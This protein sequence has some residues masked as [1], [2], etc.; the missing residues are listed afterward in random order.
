MV[1]PRCTAR[2]FGERLNPNVVMPVLRWMLRPRVWRGLSLL[3]PL[4][5]IARRSSASPRNPWDIRLPPI[6]RELLST[7]GERVDANQEL[8]AF[9]RHPLQSFV[10]LHYESCVWEIARGWPV[11]LKFV[12]MLARADRG[13][14]RADRNSRI[15]SSVPKTGTRAADASLTA[16]LRSYASTLGIGALGVTA[17]DRKYMTEQGIGTE[18]GDRVVIVALEQQYAATQRTPSDRSLAATYDSEAESLHLTVRLVQFLQAR[19]FRAHAH[20]KCDGMTIP[21]A[22]AA[23]MGQLGLNGQLLTPAVGSRCRLYML[24]T[25]APLV[26]DSPVDYGIHGICDRCQACV[27]RCPVGAIPRRRRMARGVEKIKINQK[28]CFTTVAQV[29]GC[30][31]CMKVCPVQRYGLP[32][33]LNE[34]ADTGRILGR[35]TDDLEGYDWPLDGIHYGPG[36]RPRLPSGFHNPQ[37]FNFTP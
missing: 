22:V 2:W 3:P 29:K 28:R 17:F 6:S 35:D 31:I 21:F 1:T 11:F 27:R 12:P 14:E 26:F 15:S 37:G 7:P 23:G 5:R 30:G 4:P 19:G 36:Q 16:S 9:E 20:D 24:T 18:A 32:A 8:A 34:F 13:S 10:A 25:D 33:V